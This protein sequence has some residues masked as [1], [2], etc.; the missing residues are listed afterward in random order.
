M[1]L[2]QGT[3]PPH[4]ASPPGCSSQAF[5]RS[6]DFRETEQPRDGSHSVC[7]ITHLEVTLPHLCC[8]FM[9]HTGHPV[10]KRTVPTWA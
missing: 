4:R 6:S 1:G 8:D 10:E 5:P 2:R 7:L 9:G 3:V